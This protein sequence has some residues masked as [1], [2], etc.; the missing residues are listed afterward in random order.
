MSEKGL[1]SSC[2]HFQIEFTSRK[3]LFRSNSTPSTGWNSIVIGLAQLPC[4]PC[5]LE[6]EWCAPVGQPH[7]DCKDKDCHVVFGGQS[8]WGSPEKSQ[9]PVTRRRMGCEEAQGRWVLQALCLILYEIG[10]T[11]PTLPASHGLVGL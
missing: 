1:S 10:I 11:V 6:N 8:L 2:S 4:H 5:G 9:R 3:C 7:A